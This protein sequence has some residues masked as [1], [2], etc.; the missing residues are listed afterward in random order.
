MAGK[1]Q[2]AKEIL[3]DSLPK[4]N[5]YVI[6]SIVAKQNETTKCLCLA[7]YESNMYSTYTFVI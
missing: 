5:K 1:L 3:E 4:G 7:L 2:D 6:F